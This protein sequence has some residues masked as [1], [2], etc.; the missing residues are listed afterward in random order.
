VADL[1]TLDDF[2]TFLQVSGS[3]DDALLQLLLDGSRSS[4]S[5]S[6]A[7][8]TPFQAAESGASRCAT[9]PARSTLY[10]DYPIDDITSIVIGADPRRSRRDA[11]SG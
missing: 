6:A 4:S 8:P 7:A 5:R 1:V 10:L 3:G 2:K 9:A 11:R